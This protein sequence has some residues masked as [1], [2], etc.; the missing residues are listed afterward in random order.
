MSALGERRAL[1]IDGNV[2]GVPLPRFERNHFPAPLGEPP[3]DV[4]PRG[5]LGH[6]KPGC[7]HV[8]DLRNRAYRTP[9]ADRVDC[10]SQ[11]MATPRPVRVGVLGA[12]AWARGAHLPG[13]RRDP[14]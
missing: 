3:G 1:P 11:R 13:Y 10:A 4:T 14:R 12:G 7:G 2:A 9:G 6:A 5:A 8:F